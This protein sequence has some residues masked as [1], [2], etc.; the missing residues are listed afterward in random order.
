MSEHSR[1]EMSP[2]R[3]LKKHFC[4][5]KF[6][7]QTLQTDIFW[8]LTWPFSCDYSFWLRDLKFD[9]CIKDSINKRCWKNGKDLLNGDPKIKLW[10][11]AKKAHFPVLAKN[12][13]RPWMKF[14]FFFATFQILGPL[15]CQ[16]WVVIPQN[17]K[18]VKITAPY[19]R[20]KY[21]ICY[22]ILTVFKMQMSTAVVEPYN[23]VLTTHASMDHSS[24]TFLGTGHRVRK[25]APL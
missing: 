5:I 18:K 2:K 17:V 4:Y 12:F 21:K 25:S 16:G 19:Y 22:I 3:I 15:W 9:M 24:V 11:H 1:W 6:T 14:K 8:T 13:P 7:F 10:N 23:S 20:Y